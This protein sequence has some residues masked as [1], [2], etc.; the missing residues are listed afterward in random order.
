MPAR[1][2]GD[3]GFEQVAHREFPALLTDLRVED[4]LEE[5]V[6]SPRGSGRHRRYRSV[7]DP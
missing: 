1:H 3:E 5:Q 6:A 2:L 4:D 7:E